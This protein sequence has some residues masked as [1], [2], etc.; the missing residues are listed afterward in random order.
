MRAQ[1]Y[2]DKLNRTVT[3]L[4]HLKFILFQV[5]GKSKTRTQQRQQ[6]INLQLDAKKNFQL[7][8]P[9]F[10]DTLRIVFI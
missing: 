3:S 1:N 9:D 7:R 5:T 6:T 10:S 8:K 2:H 4:F